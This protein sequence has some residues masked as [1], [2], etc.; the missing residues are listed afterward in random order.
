MER[1][2]AACQYHRSAL[3]LGR[4]RAR[5]GKWGVISTA[6]KTVGLAAPEDERT[7][8]LSLGL[9]VLIKMRPEHHDTS[10]GD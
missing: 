5:N 1:E 9:V 6:V 2:G 8:L 4:S 10:K 3:V 7:P